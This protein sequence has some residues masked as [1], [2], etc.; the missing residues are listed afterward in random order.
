MEVT[1]LSE[2][3]ERLTGNLVFAQE[4]ALLPGYLDVRFDQVVVD[5]LALEILLETGDAVGNSAV[6]SRSNKTNKRGDIFLPPTDKG[7]ISKTLT[8]VELQEIQAMLTH[9]L[10]TIHHATL[11]IMACK[12]QA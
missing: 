8:V 10:T 5:H 4:R 2:E 7:L 6:A 3:V 9:T 11:E 12:T 1:V